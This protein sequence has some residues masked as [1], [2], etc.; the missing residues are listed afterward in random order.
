MVTRTISTALLG[1]LALVLV[2][3]C[4]ARHRDIPSSARMV[5]EDRAGKIDFVAPSD[6]E[7]FVEDNTANKLLY[8]GKINEGEHLRVDP[9]KDRLTINNQV[10]RDQKIRDLNEVRVFFKGEPRADV[11]GSRSTVVQPIYVNP[12]Q[13]QQQPSHA[14]PAR[15]GDTEIRVSPRGEN[16]SEIRVKPGSST[17]SRVTVEPAHE[18]SKVTIE[19][20]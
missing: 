15:Q 11:A 5:A 13:S 17:D 16:E 14:E 1:S 12:S 4:A 18:G 9:V 6:G 10:V 7:V 2:T 3:G 8:S 19:Q 20:K